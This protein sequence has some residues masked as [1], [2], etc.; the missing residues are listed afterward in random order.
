MPLDLLPLEL[1]HRIRRGEFSGNT[2]GYC[3]GFVQGNVVILPSDW[4]TDFLQF[5]EFN[6]KPCPL[7]G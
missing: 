2:S 4:A 7:I 1:R 5:C 6:P 3:P